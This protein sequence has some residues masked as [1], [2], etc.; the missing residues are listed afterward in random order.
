M[1]RVIVRPST[2]E[3]VGELA[4]TMRDADKKEVLATTGNNPVDSLINGLA[5]IECWTATV[6]GRVLCMWGVS[7]GM[8]SLLG[9]SVGV[10]WLLTSEL[11]D[12]YP[13]LFWQT[14]KTVL[15]GMLERWGCLVNFIDCRHHQAIRWASRLGFKLEEPQPFGHAGALFRRFTVSQGDLRV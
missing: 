10:G 13:K 9:G 1:T 8:R 11:V 12:M 14:C 2:I 6:D 15:A 3:D 5:G 7:D 4:A